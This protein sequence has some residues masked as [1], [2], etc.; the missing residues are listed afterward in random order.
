MCDV[1][2]AHLRM[3][4]H[5]VFI[6]LQLYIISSGKGF[7]TIPVVTFFVLFSLIY[8]IDAKRALNDWTLTSTYPF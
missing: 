3:R 2:I 8:S 7:E 4:L 1:A 6:V 5:S